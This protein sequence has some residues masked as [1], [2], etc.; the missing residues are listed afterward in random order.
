M[1]YQ[2]P[3]LQRMLAAEYVLGTLH[4][5]AR[6]RFRRLLTHDVMLRHEVQ[7]WERRLAGLNGQFRPEAPRRA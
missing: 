6:A 4:G 2:N 5:R 3:K 1:K 7:D